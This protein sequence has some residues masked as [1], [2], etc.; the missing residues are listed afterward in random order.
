MLRLK[1]SKLR[2][3]FVV[4][5]HNS[6]PIVFQIDSI[7]KTYQSMFRNSAHMLFGSFLTFFQIWTRTCVFKWYIWLLWSNYCSQDQCKVEI[8]WEE[9]IFCKTE[10]NWIWKTEKPSTGCCH[11]TLQFS[12]ENFTADLDNDVYVLN[13]WM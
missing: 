10:K 8:H 7:L 3:H 9:R 11:F 2:F 13:C 6:L 1:K 4:E 5:I 12:T